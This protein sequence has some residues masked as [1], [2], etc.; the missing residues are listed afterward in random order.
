MQKTPNLFLFLA[1]TILRNERLVGFISV[2]AGSGCG[3][4]DNRCGH[5]CRFALLVDFMDFDRCDI[6][7]KEK[8]YVDFFGDKIMKELGDFIGVHNFGAYLA[9]DAAQWT[10]NDGTFEFSVFP[11][12]IKKPIE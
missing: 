9:H 7:Q 1:L 4:R 11:A 10:P 2:S 12:M 6:L 5:A 8:R 3:A